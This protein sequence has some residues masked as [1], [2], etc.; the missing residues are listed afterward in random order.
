MQAMPD[1]IS[2]ERAN[3]SELNWFCVKRFATVKI[4]NRRVNAELEYH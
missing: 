2:K 1:V 3:Q 4:L